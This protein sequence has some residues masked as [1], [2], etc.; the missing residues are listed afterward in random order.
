MFLKKG[1]I[2]LTLIIPFYNRRSGSFSRT[3]EKRVLSTVQTPADAMAPKQVLFS[4]M[5][6]WLL[7]FKASRKSKSALC[8]FLTGH[9]SL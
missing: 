6:I 4:M 7:R 2:Y 8:D 3:L 1:P 9:S 5:I